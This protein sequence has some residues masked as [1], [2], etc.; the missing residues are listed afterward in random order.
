MGKLIV[1]EGLDG[2]G[3]STQLSLLEKRFLSEGTDCRSYSFPDYAGDS[4]ALVRMYLSGAFGD[5]PDSVN[6]YAAGAFYAVDRYAN[7]KLHWENYYAAG[8]LVLCGR[9]TTSNAV[10]Q[11]SKLPA[12][13]RSRYIDWLCEF[14]YGKLGLP[15]PDNVIFLDMPPD[16]A[17][18]M[19]S[20]RYGGDEQKKDIHEKNG[21]YLRRCRDAALFAAEYC[22]W[23]T[24][25]CAANGEPKAVDTIA[26]EIYDKAVKT[27]KRGT[28]L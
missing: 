9:Y 14:E 23:E 13:E 5:D 18:K 26:E 10:H 6:A 17:E 8:G 25:H 20:N 19:L 15:R 3:K 24:V 28:D 11:A 2:S 7:Y 1:L 21:R 12:G 4:S 22:G 16:V 27:L